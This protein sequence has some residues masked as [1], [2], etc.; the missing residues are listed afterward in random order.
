MRIDKRMIR[1]LLVFAIAVALVAGLSACG[2][3]ADESTV[4]P[5][6]TGTTTDPGTEP[7]DPAQQLV[8]TKCSLCHTLDRVYDASKS[9]EEWVT[10]I[11]RMKRNGLVISD[12]E[13]ATV[14]EFLV[15]Q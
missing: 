3:T 2:G 1:A 15:A 9:E 4:E 7:A 12:D 6:P 13:Y 11:D 8:D 10:T 14:L 5:A